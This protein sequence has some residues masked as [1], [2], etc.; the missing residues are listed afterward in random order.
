L[1]AKVTH[2]NRDK[3][4]QGTSLIHAFRPGLDDE[5]SEFHVLALTRNAKGP[6]AK[7]IASDKYVTVV[8]G[9][10]DDPG[11]LRKVFEDAIAKGGIWG[12]FAAL[13]YPGLGANA[14]GEERQGIVCALRI[15]RFFV[16][17]C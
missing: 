2:Y 8:E 9:D 11:S 17:S 7:S 1:F 15:S 5:D 13:S 14:D 16:V 10:L 12:V 6:I 3:G 4:R